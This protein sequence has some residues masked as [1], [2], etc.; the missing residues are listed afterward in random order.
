MITTAKANRFLLGAALSLC[1]GGPAF[2]HHPLNGAPMTTFA[3]G[4]LSGV[5]HPVLGFDHLFFV[6]AVGVAAVLAGAR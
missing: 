1:A 2:A 6:I 3:D 5:G 4:L